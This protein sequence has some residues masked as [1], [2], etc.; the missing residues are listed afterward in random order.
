V[1]E[2]N[3]L[4]IKEIVRHYIDQ[5][6][7]KADEMYMRKVSATIGLTIIGGLLIL[8]FSF[9]GWLFAK[10]NQVEEDQHIFEIA[11]TE[12]HSEGK[13][14]IARNEES[15]SDNEYKI[16]QMMEKLDEILHE[17]REIKEA[18]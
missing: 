10:V 11:S 1:D 4:T 16:E 5:F 15:V 14:G 2:M 7:E 8:F 17:V 12:V 18:D 9:G 13:A 6:A 3:K